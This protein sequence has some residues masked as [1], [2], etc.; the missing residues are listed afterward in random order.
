[1]MDEG[2]Q[3]TYIG[4]LRHGMKAIGRHAAEGLLSCALLTHTCFIISALFLSLQ[5]AKA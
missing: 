3:H 5:A 2:L 1:M 4:P